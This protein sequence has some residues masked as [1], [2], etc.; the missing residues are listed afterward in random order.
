[1]RKMKN[2]WI[3]KPEYLFAC[4]EADKLVDAES[5]EWHGD[6]LNDN[7]TISLDAPRKWRHLKQRTGHGAFHGMRIII[8]GDCISPSRVNNKTI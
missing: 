7:Q 2:R 4:D 8:Y 3:L 1:F 6:G 5:F